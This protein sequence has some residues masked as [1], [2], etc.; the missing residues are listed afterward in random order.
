[1]NP[2]PLPPCLCLKNE[3]PLRPWLTLTTYLQLTGFPSLRKRA[4]IWTSKAHW[5]L[6]G[7]VDKVGES[8]GAVY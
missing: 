5:H 8:V 7:Y 6:R 1:M 3:S 2:L 4:V